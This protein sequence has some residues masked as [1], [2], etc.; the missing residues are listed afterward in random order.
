LAQRLLAAAQM[1]HRWPVLAR[2]RV[3]AL[4]QQQGRRL[5]LMGR[6]RVQRRV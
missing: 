1:G 4:K 3:L 5:V 6:L 2:L